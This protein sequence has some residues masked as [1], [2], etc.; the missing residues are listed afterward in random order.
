MGKILNP[1]KLNGKLICNLNALPVFEKTSETISLIGGQ[2]MSDLMIY[3]F[4]YCRARAL[5]LPC[6]DSVSV[7]CT[8]YCAVVPVRRAP[9]Q[10]N[11]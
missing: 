4:V 8:R 1:V 10:V 5:K 11:E 3:C 6:L 9:E 2:K 7:S